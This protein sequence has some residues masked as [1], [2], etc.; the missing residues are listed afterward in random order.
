M[1]RPS[2]HATSESD[3][4]VS[5]RGQ[6]HQSQLDALAGA[7]CREVV[8]ETASTRGE[9]SR[10]RAALDRLQPGDTLVIYQP[11]RVA[12][13][14]KELLVFVEAQVRGPVEEM[15][16]SLAPTSPASDADRIVRAVVIMFD[17]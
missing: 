13:S 15:P 14:M 8:V 17:L 6:D 16:G 3:T 1:P 12:R 2:V 5:T 10:L 9:Q 7:H 11:D 4:R